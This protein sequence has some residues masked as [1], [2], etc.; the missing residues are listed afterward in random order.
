MAFQIIDDILDYTGDQ[1]TVGKPVGS[2][3]RQGIVTLPAILYAASN[4]KEP[5][6]CKLR[7]G[8]CLT[9]D[10]I[11][12]LVAAIRKSDAIQRSHH[13]AV[14]YVERAQALLAGTPASAERF[15]LE[16]LASYI[17]ERRF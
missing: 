7:Q 13:E 10:E 15:A 12:T 8:E 2:D 17:T 11:D 3:L 4:P 5:L 14:Q 9:G 1:A 6:A 16:E